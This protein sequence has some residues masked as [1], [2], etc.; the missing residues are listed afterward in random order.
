LQMIFS[1]IL[2]CPEAKLNESPLTSLLLAINLLNRETQS[3]T[4]SAP[5]SL[6]LIFMR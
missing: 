2:T 1:L 6:F 4:M 3:K 5:P